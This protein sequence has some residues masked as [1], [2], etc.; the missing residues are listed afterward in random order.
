MPLFAA[1]WLM[2]A[3]ALLCKPDSLIPCSYKF[4]PVHRCLLSHGCDVHVS[5]MNN[6][7]LGFCHLMSVF[8]YNNHT[9]NSGWT[10]FT[11]SGPWHSIAEKYTR[12]SCEQSGQL[13]KSLTILVDAQLDVLSFSDTLWSSRA[14][15]CFLHFCLHDLNIRRHTTISSEIWDLQATQ[16]SSF[17]WDLGLASDASFKFH[18]LSFE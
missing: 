15:T 9:T 8:M 2:C 1:L 11:V 18:E 16:A 6:T 3:Q 17:I 7:F 5:T 10:E 4:L 12:S 14:F 13:Y